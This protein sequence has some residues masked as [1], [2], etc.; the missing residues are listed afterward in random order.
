MWSHSPH[1]NLTEA[2]R[3]ALLSLQTNDNIVIKPSDKGGNLVIQD[4]LHYESMVLALLNNK[5]W[6]RRVSETH[7]KHTTLRYQ[8]LIG[9]AYH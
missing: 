2:Q 7:L 4:K 3:T 6:Y 9:S 8:D 5:E 1:P